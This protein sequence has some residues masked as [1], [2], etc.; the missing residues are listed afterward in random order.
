[1]RARE[2]AVIG[3]GRDVEIE[4][5]LDLVAM[6]RLDRFRPF[7][8]LRHEL[9]RAGV[10]RL[11]DVEPRQIALE[12]L[13]VEAGDVPRVLALA[14]RRFL[15][16]IVARVGIGRQM[17]DIGDVDDVVEFIALMTQHAA[18]GIGEDIGAHVADMLVII[19]RRPAAIDARFAA[20]ERAE[21][22]EFARQTV[23]QAQG[24]GGGHRRP[25]AV[26]AEGVNYGVGV[27]SGVEVEAGA[28]SE[29]GAGRGQSA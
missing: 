14:R 4:A 1:M 16:L 11:A 29:R 12:I 27:V 21:I 23:E 25:F 20:L 13:L 10:A 24:R 28:G 22:L 18:E 17:A 26:F 8:H 3:H 2:A 5:A 15:H 7:Y 6:L 9:G 19:D